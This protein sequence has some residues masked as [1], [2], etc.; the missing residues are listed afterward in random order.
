[1]LSSSSSRRTTRI[2]APKA[3]SNNKQQIEQSWSEI[4]TAIVEI[5]NKNAS[6]LSFE[7]LYRMAYNIVLKKHSDML[8]NGVRTT[9]EDFLSAD[10][11]PKLVSMLS[12]PDEKNYLKLLNQLWDDHL[13]S[14][15]MISDVLIS[16]RMTTTD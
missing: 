3:Q 13:I 2:R 15:K 10:I 16:S 12:D 14:M 5:Q 9:I 8:Y 7:K 4:Q 11:K 1:M 6:V